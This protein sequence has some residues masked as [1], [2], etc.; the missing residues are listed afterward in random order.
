MRIVKRILVVLA[1]L[2]LVIAAVGLLFFPA[3]VTV[4]RSIVVNKKPSQ[5]YAF[6]SDLKNWNSWSPWYELDPNAKYEFVNG[7]NSV[8]SSLKWESPVKNVGKGMMTFTELKPDSAVY[9]DLNFM[10]QGT[11]K[12]YY[13]I[14]PDGE[15]S[16]VSWGLKMDA[17]A[18][19]LMRIMG[20]FMDGMLGKYFEKGLTKLKS[21]VESMKSETSYKVE[22]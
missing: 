6:M 19:P 17:G 9:I 2:I 8:G 13:T 18:N 11:A 16:K 5:T 12:S 3:Q 14:Q 22:E 20:S 1:I 7:S 21:N 15:G 4:E 10:E